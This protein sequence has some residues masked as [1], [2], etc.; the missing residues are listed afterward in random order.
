MCNF[1]SLLEV[2]KGGTINSGGDHTVYSMNLMEIKEALKALRRVSVLVVF[3][4]F[5]FYNFF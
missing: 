3:L 1:G 4:N 5:F 2:H